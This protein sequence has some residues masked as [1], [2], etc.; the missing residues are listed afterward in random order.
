MIIA[1]AVRDVEVVGEHNSKKAKI[2][3]DKLKKLQYLLTKGLYKDP[4]TAVIAEWANNGVDGVVQAGRNPIENPVMVTIGKND[5][6]QFMLS[7]EDK[8]IGLDDRDFEDICMNYLESTKEE[9]ND[10]IGHFGIGMK[11]FLSLERSAT[12]TCRKENVE[13]KYLVYEGEEFVNFDLLYQK[14]TEEE[15]GVRAEVVIKDWSEYLLFVNKAKAK[16]A[17]YD[18]VVLVI[19]GVIMKNDIHRNDLFQWSLFNSNPCIHIALKDVYY[20]IDYEALGISPISLPVAIRLGLGDGLTP[21][22]SR[23]SY[24]TND[25]VRELLLSKIKSIANWFVDKYNENVGNF[26]TIVAAYNF[27]N[28]TDYKVA[29]NGKDFGINPILG[30]AKRKIQE[31]IVTGVVLRDGIYYKGK[32]IHLLDEYSTAGYTTSTGKIVSKEKF[33]NTN[34]QLFVDGKIPIVVPENFV[35][36]IREFLKE[37]YGTQKLFLRKNGFVRKL[38]GKVENT[39]FLGMKL[40]DSYYN[41]LGL[42][43]IKKDKWRDYIK[44]WQVVVENITKTFIDETKVETSKEFADW[45]ERKRVN[46][47]LAK[48]AGYIGGTYTGINKQRGDVTL[49]YS[50][51]R[52]GKIHYK[53]EAFPIDDLTKNDYLTILLTEEESLEG[54]AFAQANALDHIRFAVVGKLERKKIPNHHQFITFKQYKTM[55]CK[56]FIRLASSILFKRAI[57]DYNK[58]SISSKGVFKLCAKELVKDIKELS[59]YVDK[60]SIHV[61]V[62]LQNIILQAAE[63]KDLYD[64][65]LWDVYQRVRTNLNKYDFL[66]LFDEPKYYDT[67]TKKRYDTLI[68]QVLLFRKKKYDDLDGAEIIFKN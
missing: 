60:N 3:Q 45:L 44:E 17:Y 28:N 13:R 14:P 53:K 50:Y 40:P 15:N 66:N 47:K 22:P 34:R 57:D 48:A 51:E 46:Q 25:K 1:E 67:E 29:V 55:S 23:E 56:P 19:D 11:S 43:A 10:T 30:Y 26:P 35:G 59:Q 42:S 68:N 39:H 54:K 63:E 37:K 52:Y 58:L 49:A 12:F 18:T 5:K 64:K 20:N 4:I 16:L 65:K 36:N 6:G 38:G 27:L 32:N 62:E 24:I 7:V 41:I 21:T 31:P 33:I 9:D 61:T 2:S 8:G